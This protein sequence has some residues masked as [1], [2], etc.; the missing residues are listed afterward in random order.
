MP[1]VRNVEKK[2]WDVEGFQVNLLSTTGRNLRGDK[3]DLPQYPFTRK[4]SGDMTVGEWKTGRFAPNYPGFDVDVL[5]VVNMPVTGQ[6][7][8]KSVRNTYIEDLE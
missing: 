2:I 6:T 5:D 8:L 3:R 7:K 4:A 1:L